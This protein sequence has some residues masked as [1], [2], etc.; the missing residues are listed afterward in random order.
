MS[1]TFDAQE[2]IT[3]LRVE[4][5]ALRDERTEMR[6]KMATM[7]GRIAELEEEQQSSTATTTTGA[8]DGREQAV[9][10]ALEERDGQTISVMQLKELY[11]R[12]TDVSN[13]KTLKRRVKQLVDRPE[14]EKTSKRGPASWRFVGLDG[15][16]E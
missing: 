11:R 5:A 8:G 10:E 12:E 4:I 14:F 6:R 9:V 2:E 16:D 3:A 1:E 13:S 7:R 15:G